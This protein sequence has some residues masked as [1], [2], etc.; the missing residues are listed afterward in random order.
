MLTEHNVLP[1]A[2]GDNWV[3]ALPSND[4][5]LLIDAGP[6]YPGAWE[7]LIA[8]LEAAGLWPGEIWGVVITHA[9]IDHCGLARRWQEAGVTVLGS[10]AEFP[11]FAEGDRVIGF[12]SPLVFA[13]MEACGT[14][15]ERIVN[16]RERRARLRDSSK[17]PDPKRE[18]NRRRE[19]WPGFLRGTP[20]TPDGILVDGHVL[21]VGERSIRFIEAPGHTPGNAVV[22]E[23]ATGALFSGDQ[24]LPHITPNP[25]I[26]FATDGSGE[27]FRSLPAFTR[28]MEKLRDL[29]A[30][31]L[32]PGHGE[33]VSGVT[34]LIEKTLDHHAKR[35]QR[36]LRF[37]RDGPLSPY[38]VMERFFPHLP[39]TR[40]WQATAEIMGHI[41]ALVE[42]GA[43]KEER[44]ELGR[45]TIRATSR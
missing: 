26:H 21:E 39:D 34:A 2:L 15:P 43:V 38:A 6:D 42:S 28:S 16:F 37:L 1:I 44:D 13:L 17:Q 33:H 7:A 31:H 25:G 32:Y 4:G 11:R 24:L 10:Q 36:V 20:F 45:I 9:H 18:R 41:D 27:R 5:T 14:P 12:Q 22:Y 29:D 23:E 8:Q 35:Q 40:L 19:R 3:Y 30:Q